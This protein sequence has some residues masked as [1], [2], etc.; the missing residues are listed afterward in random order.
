MVPKSWRSQLYLYILLVLLLAMLEYT[1]PYMILLDSAVHAFTG[2]S[3]WMVVQSAA[4]AESPLFALGELL[5]CALASILVD[6]DHFIAA[7]SLSLTAARSLS[8][9]PFAHALLFSLAVAALARGL[10]SPRW[11]ALLTAAHW[12]H[13]LR[14][15][16][17][18]GLW[19]WPLGDSP[20]IP[21][22]LYLVLLAATAALLSLLLRG[23]H[24]RDSETTSTLP[25][26][27]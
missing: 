13:L 1:V 9:R 15:A 3:V 5:C 2:V 14:D 12:L 6:L 23:G 19:L 17:R 11:A 25:M 20:P 24:K 18:R 26:E 8:S 10:L 22:P 21:L 7:A 27:V 16:L 4:P